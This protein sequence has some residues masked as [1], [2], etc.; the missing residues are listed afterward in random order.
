MFKRLFHI[1]M[2][3]APLL[4][5]I[6]PVPLAENY[7]EPIRLIALA[8]VFYVLILAGY[9]GARLGDVLV[10]DRK[11]KTLITLLSLAAPLG[12]LVFLLIFKEPFFISGF[13]LLTGSLFL[14]T[15]LDRS[16]HPARGLLSF[17]VVAALLL[18]TEAALRG[19]P[20][21]YFLEEI[22]SV[23]ALAEPERSEAVYSRNGF[24]GKRPCVNCD[25]KPIRIF[26]M[27]GSS[28]YGLPMYHSIHTYSAELQRLL[29]ERRPEESYEVFN[30]GIAGHGITQVLHSI[31][32][33]VLEHKPDVISVMSWFNDSA[34]GPGW[35]GVHGKSDRDA[36][37]QLRVLWALQSSAAYSRVHRTRLYGL[38]RFY[39]LE[40]WQWAASL[41]STEEKGKQKHPTRMSPEEFRWALEEIIKLGE[42][43]DFLPVFIFEPLHRTY[44]LERMSDSNRYYRVIAEVAA[45]HDIPLV[46]PVSEMSQRQGEWLF[47]D[48]I[49]PNI[50]GHRV[51]AE[52]FYKT[53]F[54]GSTTKRGENF[55]KSRQIDL[56]LPRLLKEHHYQL[57]AV[58]IEEG[59]IEARIRAPFARSFKPPLQVFANAELVLETGAL[60]DDFQTFEITVPEEHRGRPIVD[61]MLK[62]GI[63]PEDQRLDYRIGETSIYSPVDLRVISG[64]RDYG[65]RVEIS[66][67]GKRFDPNSRG[68]NV[69]VLD[70]ESGNFLFS[71]GFDTVGSPQRGEG[72]IDLLREVAVTS[73]Y[74]KS[75]I[76]VISVH[77]DGAHNVD[78]EA[79]GEIF[80]T[81]GGSG[82]TPEGFESFAF[83]GSPG[84]IP[85]T[86]LEAHGPRPIELEVGTD[87]LRRSQLL[88]VEISR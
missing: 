58:E 59:T 23:P 27:G 18:S 55:L 16:S 14:Y 72:L 33:S 74:G 37:I 13:A 25:V 84:A 2:L 12:V 34:P 31:E 5:F 75:P 83:V 40:G 79:L 19:V 48:F 17:F 32:A 87:K 41:L 39:T 62:A 76:V 70:G 26:A 57:E 15:L 7:L 66:A 21:R 82:I 60:R 81:F 67:A 47:Y 63:P 45:E 80:K 86:A 20:N 56:S 3:L 29:D 78:H 73:N 71:E 4:V 77:T 36:Y 65:W 53:L 64:G 8:V 52:E 85:G 43:H 6:V 28:T 54:S 24:R 88:E 11:I 10:A 22:L 49:H 9:L 42:R 1:L 35:W 61:I 44:P 30:A 50:E 69:V 46:D 68:Y 51:I 38:F